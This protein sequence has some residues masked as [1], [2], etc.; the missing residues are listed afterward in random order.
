MKQVQVNANVRTVKK[1]NAMNRL[2]SQKLIPA[3][4]YGQGGETINL[5]VGDKE[6]NQALH[7]SA[8]RNVL[9]KLAIQDNG[10]SREETVMVKHVQRHPMTSEML[11]VDFVRISLDQ[12]LET[13]I[14]VVVTG[15]AKG[16][17]EGGM[18]EVVHRDLAIRCLPAVLPENITLEVSDLGI[19]D[20]IM[21]ADLTL[22]E[23][24]EILVDSHE[25][26][27]H[28]VAP[29]VEEEKPAEEGEVVAETP[30]ASKEPE[31]IGEKEREQRRV[32]KEKA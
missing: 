29:R 7:T 5:Q 28:V 24:V 15:S 31:V 19:G 21:V 26:V 23:G 12:P 13:S 16:L 9:V 6:L 14:P 27:V 4:L 20:A 30:E 10:Q 8:G 17:K 3:V 25:P 2:R 18:L 1:K 32:E 22:P 11:H